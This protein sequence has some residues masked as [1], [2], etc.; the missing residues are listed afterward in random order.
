MEAKKIPRGLGRGL[1]RGLSSFESRVLALLLLL[2]LVFPAISRASDE[3]SSLLVEIISEDMFIRG[4]NFTVTAV[5]SGNQ[6]ITMRW[7]LPAGLTVLNG[8]LEGLCSG[9]CVNELLVGVETNSTLGP[10][11]IGVEIEYG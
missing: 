9:D 3:N 7:H 8:S 4:G 11:D 6:N 10:H 5:I 2:T 1:M